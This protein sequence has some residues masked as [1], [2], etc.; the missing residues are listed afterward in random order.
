MPK[1][2][3][4]VDNTS[5]RIANARTKALRTGKP[6]SVFVQLDSGVR[7]VTALPD[8]TVL[9]DSAARVRRLTGQM[10]PP[11]TTSSIQPLPWAAR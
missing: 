9:A 7:V 8:G 3:I 11:D 6:V 4:P 2:P 10:L 5:T 1:R